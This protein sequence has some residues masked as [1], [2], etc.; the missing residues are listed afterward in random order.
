VAKW[1]CLLSPTRQLHRSPPG[2][3]VHG[4]VAETGYPRNDVLTGN[5]ATAVCRRVR[6][7]LADRTG[8]PLNA[9]MTAS[10]GGND[11]GASVR[12][13][14]DAGSLDRGREH[15]MRLDPEPAQVLAADEHVG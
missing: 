3:P 12:I 7:R 2:I 13:H 5:A 10:G 15:R 9:A 8:M 14:G 6:D 4:S 11:D 1:D